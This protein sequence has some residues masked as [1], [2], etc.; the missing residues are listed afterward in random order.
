ME[1]YYVG[2]M[3]L[4]MINGV[5]EGSLGILLICCYTGLLEDNHKYWTGQV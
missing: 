4:P 3:N 2:E 5:D 1:Q